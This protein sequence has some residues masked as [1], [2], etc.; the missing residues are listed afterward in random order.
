MVLF[1]TGIFLF[2]CTSILTYYTFTIKTNQNKIIMYI[3]VND[4]LNISYNTQK[5]NLVTPSS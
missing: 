4:S 1:F 3:I 2:I 5:N